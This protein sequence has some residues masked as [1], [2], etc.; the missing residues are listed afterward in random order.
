[1]H[2]HIWTVVFFRTNKGDLDEYSVNSYRMYVLQNIRSTVLLSNRIQL[3]SRD[4][5]YGLFVRYNNN[6]RTV[7]IILYYVPTAYNYFNA[8]VDQ[9]TIV[10][11]P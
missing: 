2:A 1:M 3:K 7:I 6:V 11:D 8:I 4:E 10:I 9:Y 5:S